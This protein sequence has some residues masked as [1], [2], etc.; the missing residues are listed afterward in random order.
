MSW[1]VLKKQIYH[2]KIVYIF[3]VLTVH[4]VFHSDHGPVIGPMGKSV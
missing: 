1:R 2:M 3:S 4:N